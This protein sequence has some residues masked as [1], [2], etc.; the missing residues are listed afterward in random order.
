GGALTSDLCTDTW[1]PALPR[2]A[3][4]E[5]QC[6]STAFDYNRKATE[7]FQCA[8]GRPPAK[9]DDLTTHPSQHLFAACS[10]LLRSPQRGEH[11][12]P[13]FSISVRSR[14][15]AQHLFAVC[16]SLV[17]SPHASRVMQRGG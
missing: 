11:L 10:I 13:V 15:N 9:V 7:E 8:R 4:T 14:Q 5:E 17:R 12:F 6:R 3:A 2:F 16:L 1:Q